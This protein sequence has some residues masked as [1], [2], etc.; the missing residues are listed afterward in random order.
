MK[1]LAKF[2]G[3]LSNA[4]RYLCSFANAQL[5][6]LNERGQ[7]LSNNPQSKWRPWGYK[8]R[9]EVAK[10]VTHFREK[11]RRPIN[12]AQERASIAY[13]SMQLHSKP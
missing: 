9:E 7:S 3:E 2:S 4:A 13:K 6:E 5:S 10:K 12:A 1:W 8:F 11:Q